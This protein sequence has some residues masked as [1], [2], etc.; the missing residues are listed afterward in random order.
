MLTT[1]TF[2]SNSDDNNI[3]EIT[4]LPEGRIVVGGGGRSVYAV[5]FGPNGEEKYKARFVA[6]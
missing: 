3:F 2:I 6:K 4:P 5:K 1:L